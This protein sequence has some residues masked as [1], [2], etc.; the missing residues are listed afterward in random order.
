MNRL[1]EARKLGMVVC[2]VKLKTVTCSSLK[3]AL[4]AEEVVT[5]S[6]RI[7]NLTNGLDENIF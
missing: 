4:L 2:A 6:L 7:Q 3:Y 1:L 5:Q